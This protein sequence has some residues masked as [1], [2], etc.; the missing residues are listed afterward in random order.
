MTAKAAVTEEVVTPAV[1]RQRL[2]WSLAALLAML[3]PALSHTRP[4]AMALIGVLIFWRL[5]YAYF[6]LPLPGRL[7]R[8]VLTLAAL[9]A[10]WLTYGT[11]LGVV[12]GS[13]LLIV[14]AGLKLIESHTRRDYFLLLVITL[15]IGLADFLYAPRVGLAAYMLPALWLTLT[16]LVI[17]GHGER[18]MPARQAG[19]IAA[20]LL[21]P[22]V[23]VAALLFFIFPR[24][25]GPVWRLPSTGSAATGIG[26]SMA[27][28]SIS[29]LAVSSRVAFRV[30]FDSPPPAHRYWRG[31][32]LHH[33]S[34]GVWTRGNTAITS[35]P[36]V[37][38][39]GAPVRYTITLEP[40][41][42]RWLYA[43]A[44]PASWPDSAV[45]ADDYTLY[46]AKPIRE[47]R[48]YTIISYPKAHYGLNLTL[49]NLQRDLQ[50]PP[51]GNPRARLLAAR[52]QHNLSTPQ[53]IVRKALN[54]FRDG[55]FYYTL[56]PPP[57]GK[58]GIDRFLFETRR[59]FC[60]H[61]ASAF[62]FLMRAA[63]IPAHVVT[64]YAGGELNPID[65]YWTV[66]DARA[67]AWDE[68][69]L[70][71]QGWVR[72]DPTAVLPPSQ[73]APDAAA[74]IRAA[75]AGTAGN[76]HWLR[77]LNYAWEAANTFWNRW[78]M[79]YGPS[80]QKAA[81]ARLGVDY[82]SWTSIAMTMLAAFVLIFATVGAWF[83]WRAWF[84]RGEPVVR[85]YAQFCRKLARVG[86]HRERTEG[87]LDFAARIIHDR[88][89]CA[90]TVN[91]IT[92]HYVALR[93]EPNPPRDTLRKL[94]T[95]I[96][97]FQP[98]RRI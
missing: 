84:N 1:A 32:V 56:K 92:N 95:A 27:P 73:I 91:A 2:L 23:P 77:Q 18:G 94:A 35:L 59:G 38:L 47:R 10:I 67:H 90:P 51:G 58:N 62:A 88:P 55:D 93:Y 76:S 15:F 69:W 28:G 53:E 98:E 72:V 22:A 71:G 46:T 41:N 36:Q 44:A 63:G 85:L 48:Q 54:L 31:P 79:S 33:F 50:L 8:G 20:S 34:H 7:P 26:D 96:A 11:L 37:Q 74:A 17:V 82:G 39:R 97:N 64:G 49:A 29:K 80:L 45:L 3:M 86:L 83:A 89:D 30:H 57:L 12:A 13:A 25:A 19:R 43:L 6:R 78:V 24:I 21:L 81:F 61:Y 14:M 9:V 65:D 16:A 75:S 5:G 87:P 40:D 52:W 66:R 68:V 70:K 60:G 42:H 4:W